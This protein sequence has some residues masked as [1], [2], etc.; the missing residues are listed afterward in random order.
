MTP[1][2]ETDGFKDTWDTNAFKEGIQMEVDPASFKEVQ[3]SFEKS[4]SPTMFG[5]HKW[6]PME[7]EQ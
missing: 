4:E 2:L 3:S 7:L 6:F 5:T 1:V